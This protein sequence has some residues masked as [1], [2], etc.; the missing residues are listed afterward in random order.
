MPRDCHDVEAGGH[1]A[2]DFELNFSKPFLWVVAALHL[3]LLLLRD[4][5]NVF[6]DNIG[7]LT[8]AHIAE[9]LLLVASGVFD[10]FKLLIADTV[11]QIIFP[12]LSTLLNESGLNLQ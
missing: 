5:F 8:K 7:R 12:R 2:V 10:C 1:V 11:L 6:I 3:V 4:A 9:V